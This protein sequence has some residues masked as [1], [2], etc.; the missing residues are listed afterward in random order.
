[1]PYALG[2]TEEQERFY[3]LWINCALTIHAI[4]QAVAVS[5]EK[6]ETA[7]FFK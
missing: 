3:H 5:T 7:L 2:H 4:R 6:Q 1:M